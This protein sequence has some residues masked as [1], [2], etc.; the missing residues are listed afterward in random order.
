MTL[1]VL[2]PLARA[3]RGLSS[4]LNQSVRFDNLEKMIEMV[5]SSLVESNRRQNMKLFLMFN[6][7]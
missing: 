3:V 4:F 6:F 7:P 5:E 1:R 2:W